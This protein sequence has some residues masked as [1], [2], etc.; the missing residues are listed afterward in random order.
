MS[1]QARWLGGAVPPSWGVDVAAALSLKRRQDKTI[2]SRPTA[3]S[4]VSNLIGNEVWPVQNQGSRGTCN[5]F[6]TVAAEEYVHHRRRGWV[7]RA[8]EPVGGALLRGHPQHC[9]FRHWRDFGPTY[10]QSYEENGATFI[11]QSAL[12]LEKI[13]HSRRSILTIRSGQTGRILCGKHS[14]SGV[15]DASSRKV[16]SSKLFHNIVEAERGPLYGLEKIWRIDPGSNTVSD[17]FLKALQ[18][19]FPVVAGFAVL[20][21]EGMAAWFGPLAENYGRVTYPSDS[22]VANLKRAGV[23]LYAF[24]L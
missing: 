4:L 20:Q 12:A 18:E 5:A 17:I 1:E 24:W 9:I 2:R 21:D 15:M 19:G 11:A 8:I 23:T 7:H 22:V 14:F 16:E 6:A 13:R 10:Q 3:F